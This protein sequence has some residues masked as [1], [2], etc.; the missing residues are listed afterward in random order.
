M[1]CAGG[2]LNCIVAKRDAT[3]HPEAKMSQALHRLIKLKD[4]QDSYQTLHPDAI[5]FTRFYD[6]SRASGATPIDRSYHFG[7][8]KVIEASYLPLAFSDH[9]GHIVRMEL[10]DSLS[11]AFFTFRLAPEVI[12]DRVFQNWLEESM[13]SWK[14]LRGYGLDTL[15]WWEMVVNPGIRK[16]S[17]ELSMEKRES[18][19]LLLLRQCYLTRKIQL[20]RTNHLS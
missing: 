20:G 9:F 4:W 16:R 8:M 19:N 13:V 3:N 1:G 5:T 6:T 18:L 17:K 12:K 15:V 14:S 7:N 10:P 2:D 11:R